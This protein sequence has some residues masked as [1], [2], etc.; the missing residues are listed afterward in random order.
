MVRETGIALRIGSIGP[1]PTLERHNR[2][3]LSEHRK[4]SRLL[5]HNH[6]ERIPP[7]EHKNKK[8][9]HMVITR[10]NSIT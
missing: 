6:K 2:N 1:L 5:D 4:K 7:P 10:I 3:L 9:H 8:E